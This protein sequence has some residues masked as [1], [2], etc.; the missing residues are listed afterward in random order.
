MDEIKL[1]QIV[2]QYVPLPA[3][4]TAKGWYAIT[5]QV[6]HDHKY[7][8]RGAWKFEGNKTAYHCF[9]CGAKAT[10][11]DD[12][13]YLSDD[14]TKILTA[15]GIP[16]DNMDFIKFKALEKRGNKSKAPMRIDLKLDPDV[17]TLPDHFYKLEANSDDPW[18]MVAE[19]YLLHE[20]GIKVGDY[21]FY[22]STGGKTP[23]EKSWK[24]RLII[25]VYKDGKLIFYHGRD[26][27]DKKANKYL[28]ASTS[29]KD[30][31]IFGYDQLQQHTD[32]P[33]YIVEGFFDAYAIDGVAVFGNELTKAQGK[34]INRSR[35]LKVVIP[36]R[37]GDGDVLA[38]KGLDLGWSVSLPDIGNC[39]DVD[40][41]VQK[42]GKL[43][44]MKSIKEHTF[45]GLEAQ[46]NV[47]RWCKKSDKRKTATN[48]KG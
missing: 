26:L 8:K 42:Y 45:S 27:T 2:R 14:M 1:E 48:N 23:Q 46:L 33:L 17:L 31:V 22:L 28:N 11:D 44:V 40:E 43:Y 5:C 39:K 20:R 24:G 10:F 9:N 13:C 19:D 4:T 7:K 15:Y 6:C 12:V 25:P 35:R 36:D 21:P 37:K 30:N 32:L 41:A 16:Q 3:N 18:S 47:K 38:L 34:I 29:T